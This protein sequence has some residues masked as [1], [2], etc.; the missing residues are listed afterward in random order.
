MCVRD[1][2]L[3]PVKVGEWIKVSG[4]DGT[5]VEIDI[6]TTRIVTFDNKL[7]IVPNLMLIK[8]PVTN[9]SRMPNRRVDIILGIPIDQKMDRVRTVITDAL[10]SC[11]SDGRVLTEPRLKVAVSSIDGV[12]NYLIITPWIVNVN[13][14]NFVRLLWHFKETV[15]RALKEEGIPVAVPNLHVYLHKGDPKASMAPPDADEQ[16]E[17]LKRRARTYRRSRDGNMSAPLLD[18]DA[19]ETPAV[20]EDVAPKAVSV[21]PEKSE[22]SPSMTPRQHKHKKEKKK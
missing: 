21:P 22:Q 2:S 4:V 6:C 3:K 14:E 20:Q 10:Y 15:V 5:V 9:Y 7:H 18:V 12:F 8:N 11:T 16:L 13:P 17:D 1:H 19:P